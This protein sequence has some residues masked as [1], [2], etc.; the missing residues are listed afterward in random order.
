M[1]N[2]RLK[3]PYN[4]TSSTLRKEDR[5]ETVLFSELAVDSVNVLESIN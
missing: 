3:F 1:V 2:L 4:K 5:C